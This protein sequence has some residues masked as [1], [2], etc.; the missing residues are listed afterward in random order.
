M[1]SILHTK[2]KLGGSR[3]PVITIA[4]IVLLLGITIFNYWR[5]APEY[6]TEL[7]VKD[8]DTLVDIFGR[9]DKSARIM[10]FDKQIDSINFLTVGSFKGS[11]VGSM[12]LAYPDH[13]QGPYLE[14]NLRLQGIDY[15][16]V[17]TKKG[18]FITPG[19]GVRLPNGKIMGKDIVLDEHSDIEAL[20]HEEGMLLHKGKPLAL[21]LVLETSAVQKLLMEDL[22]DTQDDMI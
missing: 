12:N 11:E 18:C 4:I 19:N 20:R 10:K 15:Q 16:I 1:E 6:G 22:I 17:T 3:G 13:W 2:K 8:L 7:I 9:I 21:P 14:S 5:Q